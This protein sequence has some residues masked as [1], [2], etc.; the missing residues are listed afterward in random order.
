LGGNIKNEE[1][2]IP[3]ESGSPPQSRVLRMLISF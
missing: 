2:T 3:I 1:T